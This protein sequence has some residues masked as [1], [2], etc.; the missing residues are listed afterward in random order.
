MKKLYVTL[1]F[2]S[3]LYSTFLKSQI[4]TQTISFAVGLQTIAIPPCVAQVT[5]T[6]YGASGA[7]GQTGPNGA[8]GGIGGKGAIVRGVY[9]VTPTASVLNIFTGGMPTGTVGGYNGGGNSLTGGPGGGSTDVRIGGTVTANRVIVAGGGGGGGNAGCATATVGGGNGGN[10][11]ATPNG[12]N[13]ASITSGT[14]VATGGY[15][16]VGQTAGTLVIGCTGFGGTTGATNGSNAGVGGNGGSSSSTLCCCSASVGGGGGGGGYRGGG[17]GSAGAVGSASCVLSDRASGGGGA[18]GTN[19]FAAGFTSTVVNTNAANGNGFVVI[20]YQVLPTPTVSVNSGTVCEGSPYT[21]TPSGAFSYVY[22]TTT[23]VFTPTA[24]GTYTIE[25]SNGYGCTSAPVTATVTV[26]PRPVV[27]IS[28]PPICSSTPFIAVPSGA[29]NYTF[30][31]GPTSV[32]GT[33]ANIPSPTNTMTLNIVGYSTLTGCTSTVLPVTFTVIPRPVVTVN[34]GSICPGDSFTIT[35]SGAVSYTV[36]GGNYVVSPTITTNYSVTGTGTNGCV[37]LPAYSSVTIAP[38]PPV[39]V[40]SASICNGDAAVLTASGAVSYVW[41]NS[42]TTNSISVSPVVATIYSVTGTGVNGCIKTATSAVVI[43]PLP[44]VTAV[45]SA[46]LIC[47]GQSAVIT[48][49]GAVSYSISGG[50]FTI[51]PSVTSNYTI[52]GT[53]ANACSNTIVFTQSVSVCAGIDKIAYTGHEVKLYPN[54]VT[55]KLYLEVNGDAD[56]R[57]EVEVLNVTGALLFKYE[58]VTNRTE[59]NLSTLDKGVYLVRVNHSGSSR[60]FRI[61]KQ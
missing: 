18:A 43:K 58:L 22:Q 5:I 24:S 34:S 27:T 32:I 30:S 2:L 49:S 40:N 57:A 38:L 16:G 45:S 13:G 4:T 35:P 37:S 7:N 53:A 21:F 3:L 1:F 59:V 29:N 10:G 54:P 44:T 9:A 50:T 60:V 56:K 42:L 52:T 47:T 23:P 8:P 17:G 51:S 46:S 11:G 31:I 33:T 6:C 19:F 55:D 41:S 28:N 12:Q 39:A 26:I 36:Q 15:G 61:V 25:G 48:P 14:D 20:S